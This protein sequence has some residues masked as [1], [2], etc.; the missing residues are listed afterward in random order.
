MTHFI[1]IHWNWT[2]YFGIAKKIRFLSNKGVH[3]YRAEW[4]ALA[5]LRI[6]NQLNPSKFSLISQLYHAIVLN[7]IFDPTWYEYH[8]N[9][10]KGFTEFNGSLS[11]SKMDVI[12]I[13]LVDGVELA[14]RDTYWTVEIVDGLVILIP[15]I[16][17]DIIPYQCW[18]QR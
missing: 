11:C 14:W 8:F 15:H 3:M 13:T 18:D 5:N 10:S 6:K 4:S 9:W 16:I 17:M 1:S 12:R 2:P 7:V